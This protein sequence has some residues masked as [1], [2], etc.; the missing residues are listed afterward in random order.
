MKGT[1][2]DTNNDARKKYIGYN[3]IISLGDK[4]FNMIAE[5]DGR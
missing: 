3:G 2:I 5:N 4:T 1:I